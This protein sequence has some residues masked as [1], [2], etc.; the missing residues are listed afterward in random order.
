MD[1]MNRVCK[2][3]PDKFV[4]VYINDILINSRNKEEHEKHLRTILEMLK[5]EQ[6]YAKFSKHETYQDL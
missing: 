2:P 6:L 3:Y 1:L 5:K 4:I